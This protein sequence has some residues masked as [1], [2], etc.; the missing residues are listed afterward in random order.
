MK[1]S[2]YYKTAKITDMKE[3]KMCPITKCEPGAK[4]IGVKIDNDVFDFLKENIM[5]DED[6]FDV[7]TA[8]SNPEKRFRFSNVCLETGCKHWTGAACGCV[9]KVLKNVEDLTLKKDA[10]LPQCSIRERCR[11]FYQ[12]GRMACDVCPL[13]AIKDKDLLEV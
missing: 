5:V 6:L 8:V 3:L 1:K 2:K 9:G 7:M 11:W 10:I 4:L 12:E 13:L